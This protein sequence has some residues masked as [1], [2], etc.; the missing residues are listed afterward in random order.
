MQHLRTHEPG[1]EQTEK[2]AGARSRPAE[3]INLIRLR[4]VL[5]PVGQ[6]YDHKQVQ[7]TFMPNAIQ[8]FVKTN[9]T[10]A[11][12]RWVCDSRHSSLPIERWRC[13]TRHLMT[14]RLN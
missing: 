6:H 13:R 11:K 9:I 2:A 3:H 10:R 5:R 7:R 14:G 8:L 12:T 1:K 4:Q